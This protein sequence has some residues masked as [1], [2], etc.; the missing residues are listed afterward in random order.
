MLRKVLLLAFIAS[1][2]GTS[3]DC[4]YE[5]KGWAYIGSLYSC[6]AEPKDLTLNKTVESFLGNHEVNGTNDDVKVV[7]FENC[8]NL[9]FIPQAIHKIFKNFIA[10]R[11]FSCQIEELG[12]FDLSDYHDLKWIVIYGS[13]ITNIPG[14]FFM[15]NL[16]LI[17]VNFNR[18]KIKNIGRGLFNGLN[19][20]KQVTMNSNVCINGGGLDTTLS[21]FIN[22]LMLSCPEYVPTTTVT[23]AYSTYPGIIYTDSI[24]ENKDNDLSVDFTTENNEQFTESWSTE[25]STEASSSNIEEFPPTYSVEPTTDDATN[26]SETLTTDSWM[27]ET[28]ETSMEYTTETSEQTT[29]EFITEPSIYTTRD[30]EVDA[31]T[32]GV[33][34][35][36]SSS[37]TA[38][39]SSTAAASTSASI[40][41][42]TSL[43]STSKAPKQSTTQ[44]EP[45]T[46]STPPVPSTQESYTTTTPFS[47]TIC[48]TTTT[49]SPENSS[50]TEYPKFSTTTTSKKPY[51]EED[52]CDIKKLN[53]KFEKAIEMYL[54]L[55]TR[56]C[57]S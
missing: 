3:F 37:S 34:D 36:I 22:K 55:S 29:I 15:N 53:A 1:V 21:S 50:T 12:S 4:K 9:T 16:N 48:Y 44:A 33:L 17:Y 43:S 32:R 20:L 57:S 19:S 49:I 14:D 24:V 26:I 31:T 2:C 41:P 23:E 39:P 10:I 13:L 52:I 46:S 56:P 7:S 25:P 47:T 35:E 54:E 40:T 18:N 42:S 45:T 5:T 8:Q 30:I 38:V 51:Y 6:I 11:F 27:Q 28:T